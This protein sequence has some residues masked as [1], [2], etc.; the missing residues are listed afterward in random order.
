M[1]RKCLPAAAATIAAL[2]C[3]AT[4]TASGLTPP[5]QALLDGLN[6]ARRAEGLAPLRVDWRLERAARF[7][8]EEM[9]RQEYFGHGAF[10]WRLSHFGAVGPAFAEN[11]AWGVGSG[12]APETVVQMWLKSPG[13]RQNLLRPGF[14]RV[15][16]ASMRG[17]FLGYGSAR[18]VTVDF[19][20]T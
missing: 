17:D 13:H 11:L 1:R 4:S 5:E 20:G 15:G 3:A 10:A 12:A 2:V 18:V 8:S 14:R 19:A 6:G 7:H 16:L 9:L